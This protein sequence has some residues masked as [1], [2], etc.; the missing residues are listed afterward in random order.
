M[1]CRENV[2]IIILNYNGY[3][4]TIECLSSIVDIDYPFF[5]VILIDN[6]SVDQSVEKIIDWS[7]DRFVVG[8]YSDTILSDSV[9]NCSIDFTKRDTGAG[10][11]LTIIKNSENIGFAAGCNQGI[12]LALSNGAE[13][14][15]L[16]NNDTVIEPDSLA[17]MADYL[18]AHSSCQVT[19]PQIRL[20]DEPDRIWNCGG[21][22]KWYGIRKYY[23]VHR[24]VAEL[25]D[26]ETLDITFVTG[27][28]PLVRSAVFLNLGGF[29]EKFFFGEEDFDFSMRLKKAH[30]KVV[31]C[32]RSVIYHK[33]GASIDRTINSFNVGKAYIHYL[34]RFINLR[35]HWPRF[36][37][38]VWRAV[39]VS[40]IYLLLGKQA[41]FSSSVRCGF[42]KKLFKDSSA[43]NGVD[44]KTFLKI[45]N[46]NAEY[47]QEP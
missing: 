14:I 39:Y 17:I 8:I 33:V 15:W 4:D 10:P 23:Y 27:C 46:S 25:P 21:L 35:N 5:N 18:D 22:L 28:A 44:K 31:C 45:I 20:Y 43:M 37:W 7:R 24:P 41:E 3:R 29:T 12:R 9:D 1:D 26:K 16:L 19:T 6:A 36:F 2:S 34:N 11:E 30:A 13:Y 32:L 42:I 47:F 40:Y 38:H